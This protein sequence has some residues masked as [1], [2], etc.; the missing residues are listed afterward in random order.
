MD[1]SSINWLAVVLCLVASMVIGGVWFS[2]KVF[3]NAW[4]KAVG[5]TDKDM[6]DMA[7]GSSVGMMATW[8]GTIIASL[9]QAIFMGFMTD[10]MGAGNWSSGAMT[11]FWL[12]LG[13]IAPSSLTNKLFA[14][15]LPAWFY[16]AGNHLVTFLVM[17]AI[18]GAM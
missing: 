17:G 2:P 3:F 18:H 14:D 10:A 7:K 5:K 13:F 16:E 4:W 12:W 15:R 6:E 1:F 9:I 8:G 11:G